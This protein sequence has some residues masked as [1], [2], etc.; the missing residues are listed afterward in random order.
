MQTK[1]YAVILSA[2]LLVPSASFAGGF[3]CQ[4]PTG[5]GTTGSGNTSL[6]LDY[7]VSHME[8]IISGSAEK[9]IDEVKSDPRFRKMNGVVPDVMDMERFT[10]SAAYSPMDRVTVNL[11]IP[12]VKNNMVMSMFM[13]G[14]WRTGTMDTVSGLGDVVLSGN[15]MIYRDRDVMPARAITVGAGVKMPTGESTVT[16]S[17]TKNRVHAHMQ[18]GSGSWDPVFSAT[19]MNMINSDFLLTADANYQIGMPGSLNYEFGDTASLNTSLSYNAL[20]WMNVSLGLNYFHAEQNDDPDNKYNGNDS[21]RLT[22]YSGYTGEDSIWLSPGVQFLPFNN[23]T[24]DV[25][26]QCPLYTHTPDISQM[27]DYRV[28]AGISAGW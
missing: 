20:D 16:S 12:Y 23:W 22:D 6:R 10:V 15:Y 19:Y 13:G 24:V 27:T 8:R 1:L 18:P 3:C 14:M 21:K 28:I 9:D 11:A 5:V 4:M 25:K 26:V 7:A 17:G 2:L